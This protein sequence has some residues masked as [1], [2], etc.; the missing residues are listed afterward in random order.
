MTAPRPDWER[1]EEGWRTS[2][3]STTDVDAL[4]ARAKRARRGVL[5]MQLLSMALAL[6][7]LGVVGAALRHAGNA[8]EKT[9]GV[10]VSAGIVGVWLL[11]VVNQRRAIE[12][13]EAPADEYRATRRTLCLRRERF[14]QLGWIVVALD[15]AFLVPW[16][17]GG[18]AVHGGGF[19]IWQILTI[20]GPLAIMAGF[21]AWT[22]VLRRAARAELERISREE[23]QE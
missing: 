4:I 21:V 3:A 2:R 1:W 6:L 5:L 13:V 10:V 12:K 11:G 23:K 20:W 14:A 9:L 17:V 7:S 15:L 22:I 16:W 18:F 8:F 19:H